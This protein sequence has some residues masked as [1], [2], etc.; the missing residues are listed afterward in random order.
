MKR[1]G[2]LV[3]PFSPCAMCTN[4]WVTVLPSRMVFRCSCWKAHQQR[5]LDALQAQAKS[6]RRKQEKE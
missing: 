1:V 6:G 2:D 4:G 5:V 3:E